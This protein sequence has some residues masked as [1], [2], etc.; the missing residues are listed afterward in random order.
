MNE[1]IQPLESG[2]DEVHLAPPGLYKKSCARCGTSYPASGNRKFCDQCRQ[3]KVSAPKKKGGRPPTTGKWVGVVKGGDTFK[4]LDREHHQAL[5][6]TRKA[7][8]HADSQTLRSEVD[9]S[10]KE[11]RQLLIEERGLRPIVAEQF[12]RLIP[13]AA[14]A[15]QLPANYFLVRFGLVRTLKALSGEV[16]E[17]P[18]TEQTITDGEILYSNELAVAF[19][20]SMYRQPDVSYEQFLAQRFECKHNCLAISRLFEKDFAECH[21]AWTEEFFPQIDPRG[22]RPGYSQQEARLWLSKQSER[23]KTFLLL[24]TRN[25]FKSSWSKFYIL[26]LVAAY[27]DARVVIATETHELSELFAEELHRYLEVLDES[28]P[29]K[30]LQLFP[31]LAIAAGDGSSM[32]YEHPLRHL[33]L[34]AQTL[35][36]TSIDAAVTGGR[37]DCLV[38]DDVLSDRSCGNEKQ[39]NSTIARFSSFEKLGE[40]GSSMILVLGTPWSETPPDL[41]KTLKDRAEADPNTT[42]IAV[43]IDPIMVIKPR[44]RT[45]KLT[46]LVEDDVESF[47][48]SER[49]NWQFIR[50][51][52]M[53][54]P[55]DVSFFRSQ[56]M[57][58]FV[59]NNLI[60][61]KHQYA[62]MTVLRTILSVDTSHGSIS[63]YADASAIVTSK[64]LH[65]P[66]TGKNLFVVWDVDADKYRPAEIAAHIVEASRKHS[67]D[68]IVIERPPMWEA[69]STLIQQEG[70]RRSA[71]I[72]SH[73]IYWCP[74]TTSSVKSKAQRIK[75]L[76][77]LAANSTLQFLY[78][79]NWN[80]IAIDQFVSFDGIHRST[81]QRK[82]DI[83]DAISRGVERVLGELLRTP[84]PQK[85]ETEMEEESAEMGR[86]MLAA[87]HQAYFGTQPGQLPIASSTEQEPP[88]A[89]DRYG[90]RR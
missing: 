68:T 15:N 1:E 65:D 34:P 88:S 11:I 21:R 81:G 8:A 4:R 52:I 56:C 66:K 23:Y 2:E 28:E 6:D 20:F 47:L 33:R 67:P 17:L 25:S 9:L 45:K 22:L 27:P 14:R 70:M 75:M 35:R 79:P 10:H 89:Q 39:T 62:D 90:F 41:Y 44:A 59:L 26:A 69:L 61:M 80:P 5:R 53:R 72:P 54:N 36:S 57:V 50:R 83:V 58:E 32:T 84:P 46:D 77:P 48:F 86:Q 43:R 12:A 19:D 24:A 31:E 73:K 63:R 16:V 7:Q 74:A 3:A 49:L 42:A 13:V 30:L 71:V 78:D 64:L 38:A 40:V 29:N 60:R 85:S 37:F 51:E 76:E 55:K 82:D 18:E 87:Q